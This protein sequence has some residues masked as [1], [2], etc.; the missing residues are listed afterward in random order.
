MTQDKWAKWTNPARRVL[1]YSQEEA[2]RLN[3][4]L[5]GS[6]HLLLGLIREEQGVGA[7]ALL[8]LGVSLERVRESVTSLI[9]LGSSSDVSIGGIAPGT[10]RI[11]EAAVSQARILGHHYIGTEHLLLGMLCTEGAA[12]ATLSLQGL[13]YSKARHAV[14]TLLTEHGE[15][16]EAMQAM[17]TDVSSEQSTAFKLLL[18]HGTAD[19]QGTAKQLLRLRV[20][21]DL[22]RWTFAHQTRIES[23]ATPHSHPILTLN[24]QYL[25]D[26]GLL[27]ATYLHEQ[28][29]WFVMAHAEGLESAVA[30]FRARYPD[31]SVGHP[32]GANDNDSTY[33]HYV[34]CYLEW[35]ALEDIVGQSEAAR[36]FAF[37]R[38]DRYHAVYAAV[39][40]DQEAIGEIVTREIGLP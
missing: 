29:H 30:A 36:I 32:D 27:L 9:G 5:I 28:L 16:W 7:Q 24:T 35:R 11:V 4:S 3:Y 2:Q 39:M 6:G 34:V 33:A 14:A 40:D 8:R 22:T 13:D 17:Q 38:Q 25:H 10:K 37:W 20:Q 1:A 19:E 15:S 23:S 21:Y 12:S 18:A 26:D 31:A